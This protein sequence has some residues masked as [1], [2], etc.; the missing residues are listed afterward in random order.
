MSTDSDEGPLHLRLRATCSRCTY[1]RM[2]LTA[3]STAH[4]IQPTRTRSERR[5]LTSCATAPHLAGERRQLLCGSRTRTLVCNAVLTPA[6]LL[7]VECRTPSSGAGAG[8]LP[9]GGT[10]SSRSHAITS[11]SSGVEE[12]P[13]PAKRP[14][15]VGRCQ[16]P[17]T[18]STCPRHRRR[19]QPSIACG[20]LLRTVSLPYPT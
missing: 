6:F 18:N 17:R 9:G 13:P 4:C 11:P 19:T 16:C 2:L 8:E 20:A 3:H 7:R 1:S 14:C 15:H 12:E 5:L 10:R